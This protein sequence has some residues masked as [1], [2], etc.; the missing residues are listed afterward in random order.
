MLGQ[1]RHYDE[2]LFSTDRATQKFLTPFHTPW[3]DV[4]YFNGFSKMQR[5][6]HR[7][8][9]LALCNALERERPAWTG[10]EPAPRVGGSYSAEYQKML[11]NCGSYLMQ[12]VDSSTLEDLVLCVQRCYATQKALRS[13]RRSDGGNDFGPRKSKIDAF[14]KDPHSKV[15]FSDEIISLVCKIVGASGPETLAEPLYKNESKRAEDWWVSPEEAWSLCRDLEGFLANHEMREKTEGRLGRGYCK[16]I[17]EKLEWYDRLRQDAEAGTTNQMQ[18]TIGPYIWMTYKTSAKDRIL[19]CIPELRA[20]L[21]IFFRW[22]LEAVT[23]REL[24]A[25]EKVFFASLKAFEERRVRIIK[26]ELHK[27]YRTWTLLKT[28][29]TFRVVAKAKDVPSKAVVLLRGARVTEDT[30]VYEKLGVRDERSVLLKRRKVRELPTSPKPFD[31]ESDEDSSQSLICESIS[32]SSSSTEEFGADCVKASQLLSTEIQAVVD[33]QT[34]VAR[35]GHIFLTKAARER[36]QCDTAWLCDDGI[37]VYMYGVLAATALQ[38]NRLIAFAAPPK[39]VEYIKRP[40]GQG[41]LPQNVVNTPG[42]LLVTVENVSSNHWICLYA[43]LVDEHSAVILVFDSLPGKG[44]TKALIRQGERLRE[45]ITDVVSTSTSPWHIKRK[46]QVYIVKDWPRQE[47]AYNC[48]PFA[49]KAAE[50][51][52]HFDPS[53]LSKNPQAITDLPAFKDF[54]GSEDPAGL[55]RRHLQRDMKDWEHANPLSLPN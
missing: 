23:L 41:L 12:N 17:M 27:T 30:D 7:K 52:T 18:V 54:L 1:K 38:K 2:A 32:H 22:V 36:V 8:R 26:Q 44:K 9:V 19:Y 39:G 49:L 25:K 4:L 53:V 29:G 55:A 11:R 45:K 15:H 43:Y 33:E 46:V 42:G 51:S 34:V 35:S 24:C 3:V 5:L 14:A 47:D 28:Q 20:D 6:R 13:K 16:N 37:R 21:I 40:R 48:G 50:L 31:D 10:A